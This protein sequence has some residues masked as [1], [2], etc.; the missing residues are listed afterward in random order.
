MRSLMHRHWEDAYS[1]V[2]PQVDAGM[3]HAWPFSPEFPIDVRFLKFGR[4]HDIRLSRH[5][6]FEILYLH[7]GEVAYEVQGRRLPVKR[8]DLFAIGSTPLHRICFY[9]RTPVKAAVLYFLP[10]I[11]RG[12]EKTGDDIEYL[13]PFLVQG[14]GFPHVIPGHTGIPSQVFDLM[15]RASAELPTKSFRGRLSVKTY[16]RMILVLLVNHYAEIGGSEDIYLRKQREFERLAPLFEFIDRHYSEPISVDRA[17]LIVRTSKSTFMR[18]FKQA[19]GRPFVAYLNHFRIA[20]A[21]A[22][23]IATD[24][25]IAEVSQEVGFCDQ[26]YFGLVFRSVMKVC[27]RDYKNRVEKTVVEARYLSHSC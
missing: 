27:P 5:D 2:E 11:I 8:G 24:K 1:A 20:K 22:L 21:E 3:V 18:L 14:D 17:A 19:T 13:M 25:T 10:E 16:L 6:Y 4:R 9:G 12:T 23:L 7:S 26:S 15:Q